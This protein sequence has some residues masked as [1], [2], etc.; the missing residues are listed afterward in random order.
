MADNMLTQASNA[1]IFHDTALAD[2]QADLAQAT[3]D[4][5]DAQANVAALQRTA[6]TLEKS[7]GQL[8]TSLA[9]PTLM[10]AEIA[11]KAEALRGMLTEQ[12]INNRELLESRNYQS[13]LEYEKNALA[14]LLDGLKQ[15]LRS[16]QTLYVEAQKAQ[17]KQDAYTTQEIIDAVTAKQTQA[18]KLLDA[19]AVVPDPNETDPDIIL[20]QS[21]AARIAADIPADLV[22]QARARRSQWLAFEAAQ[23]EVQAALQSL[24]NTVVGGDAVQAGAFQSAFDVLLAGALLPDRNY[25][26]ALSQLQT[27]LASPLPS[28]ADVAQIATLAIGVTAEFLANETAVIDAEKAVTTQQAALQQ[29]LSAAYMADPEA[30]PADD[31]AVQAIQAELEVLNTALTDAINAL[32]LPMTEALAQWRAAVPATQWATLIAFDEAIALLQE[33]T[34]VKLVDL[35]AAL[36]TADTDWAAA[37]AALHVREQ[38]HQWLAGQLGSATE[39]AK[40]ARDQRR[41]QLFLGARGA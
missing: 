3:A 22:A 11:A 35:Q 28:A 38:A 1:V 23:T 8:R 34:T 27:V 26:Q 7:V 32:T 6:A 37:R 2:A 9:V 21:A 33:I 30:D 41:Q 40:L 39:Q 12:L 13:L 15:A 24:F 25:S 17:N 4:F 18:Q 20:L 29:A 5:K 16:A 31:A 36:V 14:T 10:P 19:V